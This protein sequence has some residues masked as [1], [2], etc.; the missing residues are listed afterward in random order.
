MGSPSVV[1]MAGDKLRER[2]AENGGWRDNRRARLFSFLTV[3]GE[4]L[5][6][7]KLAC[8]QPVSGD[9]S[10]EDELKDSGFLRRSPAG[11]LRQSN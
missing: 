6:W 3:T 2:F 7:V 11:P 1:G 4:Y 10:Y 8:D 9:R 5:Q